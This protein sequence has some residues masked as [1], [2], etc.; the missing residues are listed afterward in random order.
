[1]AAGLTFGFNTIKMAVQTSF[2][3]W[4]PASQGGFG[5]SFHPGT[6]AVYAST[7]FDSTPAKVHDIRDRAGD[8]SLDQNGFEFHHHTSQE[9]DFDDEARVRAVVYDEMIELLKEK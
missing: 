4:L 8:F 7:K 3:Y 1:M 9:K 2:N 6:S 5:D